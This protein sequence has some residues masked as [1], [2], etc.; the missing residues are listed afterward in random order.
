MDALYVVSR[1]AD[2]YGSGVSVIEGQMQPYTRKGTWLSSIA[3]CL[4]ETENSDYVIIASSKQLG[5]QPLK[6]G[7]MK[8]RHDSDH[9]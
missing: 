9:S 7:S 6:F 4:G 8:A 3:I 2:A 5:F 1:F